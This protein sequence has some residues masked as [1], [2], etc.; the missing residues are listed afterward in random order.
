MASAVVDINEI[1][2]VRCGERTDRWLDYRYHY[3]KHK[4]GPAF[5]I[6]F[7]THLCKHAID[8]ACPPEMAVQAEVFLAELNT[9]VV[10]CQS[11]ERRCNSCFDE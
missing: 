2:E 1:G 7:R 11:N 4:I 10:G 8:F 5:S 6:V 3:P 9:K